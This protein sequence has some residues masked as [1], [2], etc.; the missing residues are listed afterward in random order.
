MLKFT[1]SEI[2]HIGL[3]VLVL[4]VALSGIGFLQLNDVALRLVVVVVPLALG[5]MVHEIT[6][7]YVASRYG[8]FSVYRMWGFGLLLALT[9]GLGSGGRILMAAPGAVV[10]L[11]PYLNARQNGLISLAGPLSN[12]AMAGAFFP[13]SF[14]T[15]WVGMMGFWGTRIN[16]WLAFFNLFPIPP[17]D[18][19]KVFFWKPAV[20]LAMEIPVF[21]SLVLLNY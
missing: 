19:S 20:W 1:E 14:M 7:K 11:A 13:L 21:A 2:R 15:G 10:I 18:G 17:L 6:H 16:L 12:L 3:S 9:L 8:Y 5:F 4:A